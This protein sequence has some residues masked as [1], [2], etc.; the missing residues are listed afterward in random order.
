MMKKVR[1]YAAAFVLLFAVGLQVSGHEVDAAG[2]KVIAI[3]AGHQLKGN[4]SL[5]P[6]GPGS[7]TKKR[8]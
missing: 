2:S 6:N 3:D 4:S 7:K 8:K 5:E 1:N